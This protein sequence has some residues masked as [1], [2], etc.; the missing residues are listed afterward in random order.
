MADFET[1]SEYSAPN[2]PPI[3]KRLDQVGTWTFLCTF[4][5]NMTGT[6]VVSPAPAAAWTTPSSAWTAGPGQGTGVTVSAPGAH[7]VEFRS[8]DKAGN[9]ETA[10][11]VAFSIAAATVTPEPTATPFTPAAT[12]TPVATPTPTPPVKPS[13][14][15]AKPA[16]TTVAT[17]AKSGLKVT[18]RVHGGDERSGDGDGDEQGA[19]GAQAQVGDSGQG[20]RQLQRRGRPR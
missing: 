8:A 20:H 5:T 18:C 13:F 16:K 14:T 12:P 1:L 19:Q 10:K 9:V 2:S 7:A 4:H 11:S 6:A 15:L 17:F 3:T